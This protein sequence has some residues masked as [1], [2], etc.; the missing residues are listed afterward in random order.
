MMMTMMSMPMVP[1][2]LLHQ[3]DWQTILAQPPL[4]WQ[5]VDVAAALALQLAES[6]MCQNHPDM[7]IRD[8]GCG[9]GNLWVQLLIGLTVQTVSRMTM[10]AGH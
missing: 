2:I 6:H 8:H 3:N 10:V 4:L 7:D 1:E 9:T 5:M